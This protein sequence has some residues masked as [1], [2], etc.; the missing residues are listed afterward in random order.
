MPAILNSWNA[1]NLP[2]F[3]PILMILLSKFMVHRDLSDQTYLS[4][5]LLSPLRAVPY[6]M[7]N[8][9]YHIRWY[10]LSVIILITYVRVLRN[11]SYANVDPNNYILERICK[12]RKCLKS[13]YILSTITISNLRNS[14]WNPP[15]VAAMFLHQWL[16]IQ[17]TM[18]LSQWRPKFSR[19]CAFA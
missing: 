1:L 5:G 10:P 18:T 6:G 17:T 15:E 7:E 12:Q 14:R 16:R 2:I 11:G 13:L 4:L 3:Q 8:Q 19:V 9:F